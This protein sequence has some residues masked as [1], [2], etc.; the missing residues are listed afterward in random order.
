MAVFYSRQR[1]KGNT[2]P[3]VTS[4]LSSARDNET[5]TKLYLHT[6]LKLVADDL[7]LIVR[8][9]GISTCFR[10]Y[11]WDF[12]THG[13]NFRQWVLSVMLLQQY[14]RAFVR[15]L[16]RNT[17]QQIWRSERLYTVVQCKTLGRWSSYFQ[18]HILTVWAT[19]IR[20]SQ[21]M[22]L[23]ESLHSWSDCIKNQQTQSCSGIY[24]YIKC[25]ADGWATKH[26]ITQSFSMLYV[27][28]HRFSMHGCDEGWQNR[29]QD[30]A[31]TTFSRQVAWLN[32][33]QPAML[34]GGERRLT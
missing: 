6:Y 22:S 9:R 3:A 19:I 23:F 4:L 11:C 10:Q 2:L 32:V 1:G 21:S 17:W 25:N 16:Y 15:R 31:W 14:A 20:S 24:I 33:W 8:G 13:R 12:S 34:Y 5:K 30:Q 28:Q 7:L 27:P 26:V 18:P 29:G